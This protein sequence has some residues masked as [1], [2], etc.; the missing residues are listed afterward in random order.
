MEQDLMPIKSSAA[1]HNSAAALQMCHDERECER[2][3]RQDNSAPL[4]HGRSGWFSVFAE[5][6]LAAV[7][8]E[9]STCGSR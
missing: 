7:G 1:R 5:I 3:T 4:R 9:P 8:T 2:M 6:P